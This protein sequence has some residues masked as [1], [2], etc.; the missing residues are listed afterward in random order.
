MTAKNKKDAIK[1]AKEEAQNKAKENGE[2]P[3]KVEINAD[4]VEYEVAKLKDGIV[5]EIITEEDYEEK[6]DGENGQKI[7]VKKT[8]Q[9]EPKTVLF[10]TKT[11]TRTLSVKVDEKYYSYTPLNRTEFKRNQRMMKRFDLYEERQ[12]NLS[13]TKN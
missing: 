1:K 3:E 10:R 4:E 13:D 12:K 6:V 2:D 5:E 9:I 7:T 8:R 11:K